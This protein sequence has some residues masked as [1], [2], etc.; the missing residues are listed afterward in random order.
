M[1]CKRKSILTEDQKN[2]GFRERVH[3]GWWCVDRNG[4][5]L[6]K[7][8][9]SAHFKCSQQKYHCKAQARCKPAWQMNSEFAEM[10]V[11]VVGEGEGEWSGSWRHVGGCGGAPWA[12]Q[13]LSCHRDAL[14]SEPLR[15][16]TW[17]WR[18]WACATQQQHCSELWRR[19]WRTARC[20]Y[21]ETAIALCCS[22]PTET[23]G[24]TTEPPML[25]LK[26]SFFK[27][28]CT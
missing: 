22:S 28:M 2:G 24:T 16:A 6:D 20:L 15:G 8:H 17:H 27:D 1:L 11:R 21:A 18:N 13:P 9:N 5:G 3:A 19:R 12:A 26:G 14:H 7:H 10:M 25:P 4:M 23:A